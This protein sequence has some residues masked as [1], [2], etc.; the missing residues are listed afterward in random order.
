MI[1][2]LVTGANGQLGSSLCDK[3]SK[4]KYKLFRPSKYELNFLT[5]D[6][7]IKYLNL[8][9]PDYIINCAAY[10][11]VEKAEVEKDICTKINYNSIREISEYCNK[12][13]KALIHISTDYVFGRKYNKIPWKETDKTSPV[14]FYGKT[15]LQAEK[16]LL[17]NGFDFL[18]IRTSGVYSATKKNNFMHTMLKLF[19]DRKTVNVVGN[20]ISC[21]TPSWWLADVICN[22]I[23]KKIKTN[24]NKDLRLIHATAK[25]EVSWYEFARQILQ[26]KREL[27][28]INYKV[29]LNKI[30]D[31]DYSSKVLR[32]NYSVLNNSLL[33]SIGI[34]QLDWKIGLKQTLKE[35]MVTNE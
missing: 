28:I 13:N 21:P 31:K 33:N 19:E 12:Y 5:E 26:Y 4:N 7:I 6:A 23:N 24:F 8:I 34:K 3:L 2:I 29:K 17:S 10:T 11:N 14:N 30:S 18:I 35:I 20:Q 27:G 16:Y 9:S 15:K 22:I 32:P 1:K 25:G